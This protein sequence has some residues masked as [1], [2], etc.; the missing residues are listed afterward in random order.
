MRSRSE[1]EVISRAP[2]LPNA[3]TAKLPSAIRP[4]SF[5]NSA[6]TRGS[7]AWISAS[8][9]SDSA[10]PASRARRPR[11]TRSPTWKC[12]SLAQRRQRSSTSWK[13][14]ACDNTMARS[15]SSS[16][17]VGTWPGTP[18]RARPSRSVGVRLRCSASRGAVPRTSAT[19][20]RSS[21]RALSNENSCTP[22]GSR[23]RNS[24]KRTN[25][26]SGFDVPPSAVS[27]S[28]R[29]SVSRPRARGERVARIRPWCH[30]LTVAA[31]PAGSTNPSRRSVAMVSGSSSSPVNTRL[32]ARDNGGASPNNCW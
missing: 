5:S 19:S 30:D 14:N 25:A 22:V 6:A 18:A 2:S 7:S 13:S 9:M 32:P 10:C 3:T 1:P 17:R 16:A 29:I 4:W 8:A 26:A 24:A 11:I 27:R 15:T 23:E 31:T 28:G 21:E 20:A 12:F